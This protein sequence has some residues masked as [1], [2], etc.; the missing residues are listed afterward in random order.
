MTNGPPAAVLPCVP[1]PSACVA[2]HPL[3]GGMMDKHPDCENCCQLLE[4][5][6]YRSCSASGICDMLE[7]ENEEKFMTEQLCSQEES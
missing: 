7:A 4:H 5:K 3:T 2:G 6:G 1:T